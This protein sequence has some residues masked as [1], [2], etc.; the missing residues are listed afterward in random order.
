MLLTEGR[1]RRCVII[2]SVLLSIEIMLQPIS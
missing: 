2:L 1:R